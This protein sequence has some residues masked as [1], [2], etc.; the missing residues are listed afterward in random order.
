MSYGKIRALRTLLGAAAT[1]AT[2]ATM[3]IALPATAD[4]ATALISICV[5]TDGEVVRINSSVCGNNQTR[6]VWNFPGATGVPGVEGPTGAVGATGPSGPVGPVGVTGPPGVTGPTGPTGPAGIP[7]PV[8]SE[9]FNGGTGVTGQQGPTGPVGNTGPIGNTGPGG[10]GPSPTDNIAYPGGDQLAVITGGTLGATVGADEGPTG[11]IADIDLG[12][13]SAIPPN[14][15]ADERAIHMGPG[16]GAERAECNVVG[17]TFSDAA[18]VCFDQNTLTGLTPPFTPQ[19]STPP[20]TTATRTSAGVITGDPAGQSILRNN[21]TAVPMPEGCLEYFTVTSSNRS[22]NPGPGA[23][24]SY[25]FQVWRIHFNQHGTGETTA[26]AGNNFCT[27]SGTNTSCSDVVDADNFSDENEGDL[28]IVRGVA[29][30]DPA[31]LNTQDNSFESNISWSASYQLEG[32]ILGSDGFFVGV[33]SPDNG[34]NLTSP[35]IMSQ[36]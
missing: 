2:L 27:I 11:P 1:A 22:V 31:H 21:S 32:E 19:A 5:K 14:T 10:K 23:G 4:A 34:V 29:N 20:G 33:G 36:E 18:A 15:I 28:L 6:L 24:Y 25:G 12:G 9:G 8:G 17:E 35:C 7:G 13:E 26:I 16:N 30:G 3:M